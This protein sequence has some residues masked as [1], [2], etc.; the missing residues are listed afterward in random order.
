M[1]DFNPNPRL[2]KGDGPPPVRFATVG[3]GARVLGRQALAI[4]GLTLV[5]L[6][7]PLGF[8]TPFIPIG[9]P[10]G[11]FGT[12]LLARNS[13]WGQ[14]LIRYLLRRYPKLNQIMP[15]WLKKLILGSNETG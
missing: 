6:S 12:A 5:L 13:V 4:L 11:F 14:R 15:L 7:V 2:D 8:L 9:F 1:S 10:M 3:R